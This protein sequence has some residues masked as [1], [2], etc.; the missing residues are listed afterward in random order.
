MTG[1]TEVT[2]QTEQTDTQTVADIT[3]ETTPRTVETF[4]QIELAIVKGQESGLFQLTATGIK[5]SEDLTYEQWFELLSWIRWAR[6]KLTIGLADVMEYG[7]IKFGAEKVSQSLE[8]LEFE[9][10]MVKAAI[11]I[12]SVPRELR[13][14]FLTA[15]HYVELSRA[16]ISKKE[17][18]KWA[19]LAAELRLTPTQ[20]RLSMV[21]GEVVD[22][23]AARQLSTGVITIPGLRQEFDVWMHRVGGIEG[24]RKM[25][26]DTKQEI[27]E[28]IEPI[29]LF[30]IQLDEELSG[31]SNAVE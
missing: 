14:P 11:A 5:I 7:Q 29:M 21:E 1:T 2:Q 8:Q 22:T 15:E 3:G 12:N 17:K 18:A 6:H 20:L 26:A 28:E 16:E 13:Y 25:D 4:S 24:V 27:Y 10:P 9:L 31:T 19:K 23:A 30:A